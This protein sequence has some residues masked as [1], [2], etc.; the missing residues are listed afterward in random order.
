[1]GLYAAS[2]AA[3]AAYLKSLHAELHEDGVRVSTLYPMG[4][5]DTPANR[6]AMPNGDPN[7]WITP[8]EL[9]ETMIHAATRTAQGHIQALKVYAAT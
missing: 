2:K 5:V 8:Q 9:A 4:V 3:V 6:E 7:T 1:M